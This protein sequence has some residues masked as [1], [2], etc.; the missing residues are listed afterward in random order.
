MVGQKLLRGVLRSK[1]ETKGV[2]G[3]TGVSKGVQEGPEGHFLGNMR[4]LKSQGSPR[5]F[6]GVQGSPREF[7][8]VQGSPGA[9]RGVQRIP[10]ESREVLRITF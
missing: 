10:N 5:E 6:K 4:D 9:Y 1:G 7:K 8:G 2:Q 3:H